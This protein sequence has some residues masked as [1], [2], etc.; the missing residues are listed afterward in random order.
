MNIYLKEAA[1]AEGAGGRGKQEE[2]GEEEER[3]VGEEEEDEGEEEKKR[4]KAQHPVT[5]FT[6]HLSHEVPMRAMWPQRAV[7]RTQ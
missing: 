4:T 2:E 3:G 6:K 1:A 5:M 7:I